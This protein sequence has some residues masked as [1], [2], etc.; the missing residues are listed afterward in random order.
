MVGLML[1]RGFSTVVERA[2]KMRPRHIASCESCI[3]YYKGRGEEEESCHSSESTYFDLVEDQENGR[4]YCTYWRCTK[5]NK[6]EE[7]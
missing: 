7:W 1:K 6:E 5:E 4:K 2:G 3:D